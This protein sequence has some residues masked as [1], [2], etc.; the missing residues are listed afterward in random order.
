MNDDL[1]SRQAAI[2]A[3]ELTDWYHQSSNG[4]MVHGANSND[5]QAWYKADEILADIENLPSA[6]S[7]VKSIGYRECVYAM[8][9]MWI[10]KVVTDGEYYRIMDKLNARWQKGEL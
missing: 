10:D 9:K 7:E 3:I 8:M 1:I 5:H 2:D 4:E 6:Q